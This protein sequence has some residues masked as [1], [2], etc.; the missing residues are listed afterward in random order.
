MDRLGSGVWVSDNFQ[1]FALID[2][3]PPKT[4]VMVE[5]ML[6]LELGFCPVKVVSG[7]PGGGN[8]FLRGSIPQLSTE[9]WETGD[10]LASYHLLHGF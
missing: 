9:T 1:I 4:R 8:Y 10:R 2:N 3:P 5:V 6:G 7:V